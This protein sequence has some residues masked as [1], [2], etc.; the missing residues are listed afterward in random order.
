MIVK[1][2]I[3]ALVLFGAT[4]GGYFWLLRN[5][6]FPG[7]LLLALFGSIGLLMLFS[8]LKQ[9]IFGE[10]DGAA[11]KRALEGAPLQEGAVEAVWGTI[12]PIGDELNAPISGMPCVAYEY[13]AK[14][15]LVAT[16]EGEM[17]QQGSYMSGFA[18]TPSVIQSN[19]G[20]VRLLGFNMLTNFPEQDLFMVDDPVEQAQRYL[21]ATEFEEMG[22]KKIGSMLSQMDSVLADDDGAVRK[23]WL[24]EKRG[25]FHFSREG[26]SEKRISAGDIVT[27][28]G[29]W[30]PARGGLVPKFGSKKTIVKLRPGG[31]DEMVAEATKRP[32]GLLAFS[33]VWS[34]FVHAFIYL[35]LT[36]APG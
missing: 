29:I 32:W 17:R 13:D 5:I 2:C 8:A 33:L 18:L 22:L 11:Y 16:E 26:L 28:V 27:A 23:D 15:P 19:R 12:K 36:R 3:M 21:E 31:G 4:F 7:N 34:G 30:D 25:S 10:G 1:G 6:E 20:T 9:V 35:A 24:M 14:K